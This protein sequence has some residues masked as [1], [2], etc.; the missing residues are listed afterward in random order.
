MVDKE[1]NGKF[2]HS[3]GQFGVRANQLPRCNRMGKFR[4]AT[5]FYGSSL[6]QNLMGLRNLPSGGLRLI[7]T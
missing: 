5:V 2:L 1:G 6:K 7:L 3:V 4:W